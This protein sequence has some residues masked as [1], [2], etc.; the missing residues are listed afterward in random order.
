ML[1]E[2]NSTLIS[3]ILK[4]E[5][6][7]SVMDFRH[8]AC[9]NVIYKII[10][11]IITFR[12]QNV[13]G[14]VISFDQGAFVKGRSIADNIDVCQG[15]IRNY[16][17]NTGSPRC[18]MKLDIKKAYDTVDWEFLRG[19]LEGLNFPVHFINIIMQC[20]HTTKFSLLINGRPRGFVVSKRDLRQGDPVSPYLFVIVMEYF[21]RMLSSVHN[22]RLF[23]FHPKCKATRL[24]HLFFADDIMMMAK[25]DRYSPII[26]KNLV[27]R[28]GSV[29]GLKINLQKSQI[30][31][32]G[33][34]DS[35]KNYLLQELGFSEGI[36]PIRYLGLPLI[37]SKLSVR[38]CKPILDKIRS[39]IT[40]WSARLLTYAGRVT[41]VKSVLFHYQVFWSNIFLLPA[42]VL[43][44]MDQMCRSFIWNGKLDQRSIFPV[45][46]EQ[47]CC[48][49]EEG[50]LN[51]VQIRTWN[52]AACAKLLWKMASKDNGL[53]QTWANG[54]YL[55][56][57]SIWQV[58]AKDDQ[59]WAWK[60]VLKLRGV[61]RQYIFCNVGDGGR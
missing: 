6:P 44:Q 2:I 3:L 49:K 4:V 33:V 16:H 46:W 24:T 37:A 47:V 10:T 51:V 30:F 19:A 26:L 43:K 40:S 14:D 22:E 54:A 61:I 35:M 55:Q 42:K 45:S 20:L 9:C 52:R 21:S 5:C 38:D 50:G 7:K 11:K 18:L 25:A 13:L 58:K 29:S 34:N 27:D 31:F 48:P 41:L 17:R 56:G 39:R 57:N 32:C 36:L 60:K 28:F 15:L 12:L 23:K 53:W 1:K 8:I 59:S